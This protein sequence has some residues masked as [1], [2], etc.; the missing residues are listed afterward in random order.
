MEVDPVQ[1]RRVLHVLGIN[2]PQGNPTCRMPTARLSERTVE[3]APGGVPTALACG[4]SLLGVYRDLIPLHRSLPTM[5]Y[6][7]CGVINGPP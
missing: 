5:R 3:D 1:Q 4:C 7:Q 2:M 6:G